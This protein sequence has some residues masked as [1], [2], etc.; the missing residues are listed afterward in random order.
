MKELETEFKGR[1]Q[2]KGFTFTQ[3]KKND[4]GYIYKVNTGNNNHYEVFKRKINTKFNCISYPSDKSF[5]LWAWTYKDLDN[6]IYKLE[7]L[8][9]ING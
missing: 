2:V 4:Y 8:E 6:A 7:E 1:G 3:I 5:G 9:V